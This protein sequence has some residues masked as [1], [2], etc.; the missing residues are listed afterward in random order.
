MP[1][2]PQATCRSSSVQWRAGDADV[3]QLALHQRLQLGVGDRLLAI[4]Q[5]LEAANAAEHLRLVEQIA[6]I[7]QPRAN[8][9]L[10]ECL[11]STSC[12]CPAPTVSGCMIS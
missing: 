2:V 5:P 9:C 7:V 10:P 1:I 3:R 6:E 11:P 8:A 12:V 4:G